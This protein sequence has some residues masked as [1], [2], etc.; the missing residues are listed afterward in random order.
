MIPPQECIRTKVPAEN[1]ATQGERIRLRRTNDSTE[2]F[3]KAFEFFVEKL[4]LRGYER[5]WVRS[6]P[7]SRSRVSTHAVRKAYLKVTHSSSLNAPWLGRVLSKHEHL[8]KR[9]AGVPKLILA[10]QVRPNLFRRLYKR[11][12]STH[13]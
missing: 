2:K 4:A 9:A 8:S 3:D 7:D 12:W 5:N 1:A 6:I 10:K 13:G 11:N